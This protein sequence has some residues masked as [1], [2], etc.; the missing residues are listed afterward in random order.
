MTHR[1]LNST[2]R[3]FSHTASSAVIAGAL[4]V[5]GT[6]AQASD[7]ASRKGFFAF[8]FKQPMQLEV[9]DPSYIAG[10]GSARFDWR[11]TQSEDGTDGQKTRQIVLGYGNYVCTPAGFGKKSA[12]VQR[13]FVRR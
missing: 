10:K 1:V 13:A 5:F 3:C 4:I 2:L 9:T 8:L 12:C 7:T 11:T 6:Q